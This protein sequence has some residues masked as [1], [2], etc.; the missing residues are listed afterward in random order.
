MV[1]SAGKNMVRTDD[2]I[3]NMP[4]EERIK[5]LKELKAK[6]QEELEELMRQKEEE[7]Q[8]ANAE[9]I[10]SEDDLIE[11]DEHREKEDQE[12]LE[13]LVEDAP[14]THL[15]N[16][17]YESPLERIP[18]SL[19]EF[20][21]YNVYHEVKSI[22]DNLANRGYITADEERRLREIRQQSNVLQDA[23]TPRQLQDADKSRGNYLSRVVDVLNQLDKEKHDVSPK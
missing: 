7:L 3:E 20:T 9:L 5:Y 19:Y 4:P 1:Y 23:Y 16:T 18:A 8:E 15:D 21:D 17:T 6:K 11:E 14:D 12:A 10:K 2:D 22:N 13:N